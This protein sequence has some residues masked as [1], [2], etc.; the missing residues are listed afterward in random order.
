[1]L[2]RAAA[3]IS[4]GLIYSASGFSPAP[5]M[6]PRSAATSPLS[7]LRMDVTETVDM[8]G[9]EVRQNRELFDEDLLKLGRRSRP[10]SIDWS[11]LRARLEVEFKIPEDTLKKYDEIASEDLEKAYEMMQLCRQF[12][13]ACNQA[14][15]QGNIRGFMHLD[16]GQETI[17]AWIADTIKKGD[18]KYSYYREH[19]HAIASGVDSGAVMAELFAKDTGTCRGTGGSMHIY[20]VDTHFQGGWALV[21]EQL[22]YA[23][24]AARSILL[25][26]HLDPEGMKDDDR[27]SIVFIGEGGAQNGR[28]AECLNA[29][30]KEKLPLLFIVIDNGR[31]INT[32]T[33]DVAANMDIFAQG[34]HY[35]V[36]GI[37]V[38]GDSLED[39][40]KTG[41]AVIDYVRSKG[42]AILQVH[43]YRFQGHSPADPEH[44]RGRK[45]EKMWARAEADPIKLFE[46]SPLAAIIAE[47]ELEAANK[48]SKAEVKRAIDFAKASE[49]PPADLAK[50]LEFPDKPDT[51]YNAKPGPANAAALTAAT[52]DPAALAACEEHIASLRKLSDD[53][54]LS[55]GDALN[56]AILEEMLRDPKT[57]CHAEDLQAG[58]SYNIPKLTQQTFGSLRAADEII[59][60]GHFIGKALGEGMNGY[61]PI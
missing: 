32:F 18:I 23:V 34:E 21:S 26:R 52:T 39:T 13:N 48:R 10:T 27:I 42:P 50:E 53:G 38:D 11:N 49:P 55:I 35:G 60:E 9:G 28:M 5:I 14:Y 36:P 40:M 57:T 41:R 58:S 15:M 61:R 22:P 56:L 4:L 43:T 30:A 37:K 25:D 1:M 59:D 51:D 3:A 54:A 47:G 19:T 44:E 29:A 6:Q 8:T 7:A 20:D 2:Y 46:S 33:P 17:P 24:G 16:N 12:E 45:A 31:A